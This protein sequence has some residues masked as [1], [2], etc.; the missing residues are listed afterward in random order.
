M[1]RTA[2]T[3]AIVASLTLASGQS[4]EAGKSLNFRVGAVKIGVGGSGHGR[5]GGGGHHFKVPG[6]GN[7]RISVPPRVSPPK[8]RPPVVRP[9]VIRPPVHPPIVIRPPKPPVCRPPVVI[10]PPV[11]RPKPPIVIRPPVILPPPVCIKPPVIV[12]P[13]VVT[14]P[15]VV[16]PTPVLKP[17][18]PPVL[19]CGCEHTCTCHSVNPWRFGMACERAHSPY[20]VGLRVAV[21]SPGGP[22]QSYGLKVGDILLVAGSVNLSQATSNEH[23][24]ALV[25]SAVTPEGTVQLTILDAATGQL[26]NLTMAPTPVAVGPAPT[27]GPIALNPSQPVEAL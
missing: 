9:P 11:V 3:A 15:P 20:G 5:G 14:P 8:H 6:A 24:V 27:S 22:A 4:A 19:P 1:F 17:I 7:V 2:L 21:I 16:C 10:R 26:A 13:P 18:A 23:G 25:Q 12:P